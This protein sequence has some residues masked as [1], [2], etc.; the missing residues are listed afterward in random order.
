MASSDYI[1]GGGGR[2]GGGLGPHGPSPGS[3]TVG[4]TVR[5]L[6]PDLTY[7]S[8]FG[9]KGHGERQFDT[10]YGIAC[11]STGKVYVADTDNHCIQVFTAD[12]ERCL[13]GMVKARGNLN[14]QFYAYCNRH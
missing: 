13:G 4:N 9:N 5:V 12:G 14:L 7:C 8:T 2:G 1:G 6:N 3:A 10:P 11:D